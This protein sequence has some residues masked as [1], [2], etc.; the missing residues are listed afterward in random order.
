MKQHQEAIFSKIDLESWDRKEY[1]LHYYNDVRC[2]YSVTVNVD[3]TKI[4]NRVKEKNLRLYPTLI[5]WIANSVNHFRFLRF[6]HDENGDIGYFEEVNPSYTFMPQGSEKFYVLWSK[7]D[8]DFRVFYDHCVEV[9][10]TCDTSKMFPMADMPRN[11]F[12]ISSIPWIEFSAF[13]LNVFSSGTHLP[14]IFTTGKLIKV[15][16][17]VKLPFS[18]QVHH[19]V[20][21]GYHAGQFFTYLQQLAD[22]ANNWLN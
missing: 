2:T 4:Y 9:M 15:N 1:F 18:L 21:D 14:P 19:S 10:D 12:D 13:N 17:I 20:C 7:Y 16:G 5:W 8:Q 3:I 6:N 11:C 22:K